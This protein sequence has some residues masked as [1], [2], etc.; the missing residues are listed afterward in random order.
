MHLFWLSLFGLI[1]IFWMTYGLKVAYGAVRLPWL[2]DYARAAD[3]ECPR[4]SLLFAARDE[5]EKLPRALATM[6]ALDYPNLE[7]VAVDDRSED[8]TGKIL[9]EFA[10]SHPQLR[11]VHV[12]ELPAGWLG[13]PHAL[14]KAYEASSGEWLVFTDADV[15]FRADALRRVISLVRARKMDHL[16]LLGGC[17]AQRVLGHGA[18]HLFRHGF[19]TGGGFASGEQSELAHLCGCWRVSDAEAQR[20]RS[21]RHAPAAGNGS[22]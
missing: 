19:S 2:K 10:A 22:D 15:T 5:E 1:A 13:K 18:D 12:S 4:I 9:E 21:L 14:Q 17:G 6:V 16:A 20:V 7:I 8:A 3:A 11:A